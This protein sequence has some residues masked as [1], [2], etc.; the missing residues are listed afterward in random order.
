M[1]EDWGDEE[2][3]KGNHASS[4]EEPGDLEAEGAAAPGET[5]GRAFPLRE[6]H[7]HE[8]AAQGRHAEQAQRSLVEEEGE[9][10]DY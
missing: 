7:E 3:G 8:D 10:W 6:E 5:G 9:G 1:E 4:L 2:E